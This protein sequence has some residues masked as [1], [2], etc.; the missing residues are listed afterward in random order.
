M[1]IKNEGKIRKLEREFVV[2]RATLKE[3]I[4]TPMVR[5]LI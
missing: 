5:L 4:R 2:N 3:M 1:Y